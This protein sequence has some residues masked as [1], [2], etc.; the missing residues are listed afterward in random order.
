MFACIIHL[1]EIADCFAVSNYMYYMCINK[2]FT[3]A[4]VCCVI[5]KPKKETGNY[6]LLFDTPKDLTCLVSTLN[7]YPKLH[8]SSGVATTSHTGHRL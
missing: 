4:I 6:S 8:S 5:F 7:K 3:V 1:C 2:C